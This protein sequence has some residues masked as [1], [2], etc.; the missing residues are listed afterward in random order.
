MCIRDSH[1][2]G[3]TVIPPTLKAFGFTNIIHVP[4]QDVVSGDFPTVVSPN[5]AEPAALALAVEK[6]Q[7]T[8]AEL[9]LAS[10]PDA[11]RVGAAVKNLSLIHISAT[12]S[13]A[14]RK[15]PSACIR[16]KRKQPVFC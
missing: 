15:R 10:D 16:K 9:V 8:D 11:D 13:P 6:A 1:G 5:P 3:V 2:T 12:L 7:E 14:K 4:E